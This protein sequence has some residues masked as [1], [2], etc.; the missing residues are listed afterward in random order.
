MK[1]IA[2]RSNEQTPH[3]LALLALLITLLGFPM[4]SVSDEPM[5]NG[6][7][8]ITREIVLERGLAIRPQA[9]ARTKDGGYVIAGIV[10]TRGGAWAV[11]TNAN[12]EV[13]WR[14]VIPNNATR[15][16]TQGPQYTGVAM[17]PDDSAVLCGFGEIEEGQ[18]SRIVGISTRI[19]RD[20]RVVSQPL[21]YP[22][23][24]NELRLTYFRR[25]L[26]IPDGALVLGTTTKFWGE[27]VPRQSSRTGLVLRLDVHGSI[28]AEQ[29]LSET[30]GLLSSAEVL[31]DGSVVLV[32]FAAPAESKMP[33][34]RRV[35]RIS[36]DGLVKAQRI[37]PGN[38]ML[39]EPTSPNSLIR[40][41]H[42]SPKELIVSTLTDTLEEA[43]KLVGRPNLIR[44]NRTY[45]VEDGSLLLFGSIPQGRN[46]STAGIVW[47][48][49][50]LGES[51]QLV[52]EPKYS[53]VEV[54]DAVPTANPREFALVRPLLNT[55]TPTPEMGV[56]LT[57]VRV[58]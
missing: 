58:R 1:E 49:R 9:I 52:F 23:E 13:Q 3:R 11:R 57:T 44:T 5:K 8:E 33:D 43:E 31:P 20:G 10:G 55:D 27:S 42:S 4:T 36:T 18:D 47:L 14:H 6:T 34:A 41:I 25:C 7:F 26:T 51:R 15:A 30:R 19:D 12:G 28:K 56:A 39:V 38:V 53:S 45:L 2:R 16:A 54:T 17:L 32:T 24:S 50:N 40:L 37:L 22:R 48:S 21:M 29:F 35:T 46:T